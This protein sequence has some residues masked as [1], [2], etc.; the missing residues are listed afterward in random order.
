M[1][2]TQQAIGNNVA[3]RLTE[4][5]DR[6]PLLGWILVFWP[7]AGILALSL[8][9]RERRSLTLFFVVVWVLELAATEFFYNHDVYG[10]V[11]SRFNS[12]L[13]WWSWVYAGIILTVG[14]GNLG[15]RSRVC[16][17][18]TLVLLLPLLVFG[19]DL[20]GDFRRATKDAVGRMTGSAWIERDPVIRDMIVEMAARPDGVTLE[21]GL[22]LANTESPAIS[23]FAGKQSLLGWPW[24][25]T[26]WRGPFIEIRIRMAQITAFYE[27][28]LPDPLGWLLHYNVRY[29]LWLPRDNSYD[30]SRFQ[31]LWDKIR[32][33]YF[34]HRMYGDDR[35]LAVGFWERIDTPQDHLPA[36]RAPDGRAEGPRAAGS[37]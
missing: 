12:T 18:G 3:F 19:V 34:W 37:P 25:E 14:A 10:G 7:V 21:S 4:P 9:N 13:K 15:S 28:T 20:A 35:N 6:T 30:N 22:V 36:A 5:D 24:H 2:F 23:L 17:Y 8:F 33:R 26:T 32:T 29:V 31:P 16:R 11:W 1:E 27:G